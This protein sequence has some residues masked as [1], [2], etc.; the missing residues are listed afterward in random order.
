[1]KQI[2]ILILFYTTFFACAAG[3]SQTLPN[4]KNVD[5]TAMSIYDGQQTFRALEY[6]STADPASQKLYR[7]QLLPENGFPAVNLLAT[8]NG[9]QVFFED[10]SPYD[11]IF[12]DNLTPFLSGE[13]VQLFSGFQR[14]M[15]VFDQRFA[16]RGMDGSGII[17][18]KLSMEN[19]DGTPKNYSYA[20]YSGDLNNRFFA[21]GKSIQNATPLMCSIDIIAHEFSHAVMQHRSNIQYLANP[22]AEYRSIDEGLADV[23]GIYVKNKIL[24][25]TPQNYNWLLA[26]LVSS[27]PHDQRN[28][29]TYQSA[30]TYKGQFYVNTCSQYYDLNG[31]SGIMGKWFYLLSTGTTGSATNDLG[32]TYT[33]LNGIGVEKAI[34]IVWNSIPELKSF[35]TYPS[36]RL[37]TL[38]ATEQLYGINSQEY[39]AV[40]KAWC[41]VGVCDNNLPFFT[42]AP[43]NA[44]E[45]T[46]PWPEIKVNFSW[47][48]DPRVK[49]VEVQMSTKYDFSENVQVSQVSNFDVLFK[50]GGGTVY[51]GTTTGFY[52]PDETVYV[53][54]KITETDANFC[55]GLNPLCQLYQQYS[56]AHAFKLSNKMPQFWHAV[57]EKGFTVNAWNNPAISWKSVPDAEKYSYQVASDKGFANLVYSESANHTGNFAE[58][59][60]I[61]TPLESDKTYYVRVRAERN[62]SAK[63][64]NNFGAWSKIDSVRAYIPPTSVIQAVNQKPNDPATI[65]SGLGFTVDWYAVPGAGSF[66]VQVA[67]DN[68]FANI[69]HSHTAQG[70]TTK[71]TVPLPDVADQTNLY[72]RVLPRKGTVYSTCLNVWRI[73]TDKS[74]SVLAM[75]L[76]ANGSPI[77]YKIY[78][79]V[80][81]E[82]DNNTVDMNLVT[83]I[84][85]HV[86]EKTSAVT[87]IY[88]LAGK[89]LDFYL[90]DQLMFDDKQGIQVKV[91]AI[92]SLGTKTLLSQPFDYPICPDHPFPKFPSDVDQ[93]DPS[94]AFT[95]TWD[96]SQ[97]LKP[98]DQYLVTLSENGVPVNGFNNA[99]TTATSMLVAAGKLAPN[100]IYLMKIKN[101]GACPGI[102]PFSTLVHTTA[103]GNNVPPSPPK[104]NL[105]IKLSAF[106]NDLDP[107]DP[108]PFETSDF[109]LGFELFDPNGIKMNV[110][111]AALNPV[112]QLLVD[113][114]NVIL[115]LSAG[116]Q[117]VGKYT[118]KLKMVD[119]FNPFYYNAFDQP[120]FSIQLNGQPVIVNHVII[121]NPDPT[122][123]EW[124]DDF[125]FPSIVLDLK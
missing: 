100:K 37:T 121:L 89:Q 84:E 108:F 38:K 41:A 83:G 14:V 75:T 49:K 115:G 16:W 3:F 4:P 125:Q 98:G 91:L 69:I 29:K 6:T 124:Q 92:N 68:A 36:L 63:I 116:Q 64:I 70:N 93:I 74:A 20:Y 25:S 103:G 51:V 44:V 111:D 19:S 88:T 65:V 80:T 23:F 86:T 113:S 15:K 112:S 27:I 122:V 77:P 59:G 73:K 33:N 109:V 102:E 72:V 107:A 9:N 46:E 123:N 106:R 54:A 96:P 85:V 13:A 50:P 1:M 34:Q 60:V 95:I 120:K 35:T 22:C 78:T 57:P 2:A 10:K 104:K 47:D 40:E 87:T 90:K 110:V 76:P 105:E 42:I 30:D 18:V 7:L 62:N 71:A 61:N 21:F 58:S 8:D 26:E 99:A 43:A 101:A 79:G 82:W 24:N 67:T 17:P 66:V 5:R 11:D 119:I 31:A 45:N 114:E 52:H 94:K 117:P 81:F 39:Q 118:L 12:T 56:P 28:P 53:R 55:K 48:N 32:Y 97:W